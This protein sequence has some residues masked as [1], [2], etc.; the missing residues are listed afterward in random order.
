[1]KGANRRLSSWECCLEVETACEMM[2]VARGLEIP[3]Q[4]LIMYVLMALT[5]RFQYHENYNEVAVQQVK[6]VQMSMLEALGVATL[7][8]LYACEA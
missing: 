5:E 3:M 7:M 4:V 8:C 1:M 2:H 6:R